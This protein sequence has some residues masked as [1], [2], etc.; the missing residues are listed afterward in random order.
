MSE[1]RLVHGEDTANVENSVG[2]CSKYPTEPST[3]IYM[4]PRPGRPAPSIGAR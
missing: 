2:A 1:F 4:D 3:P